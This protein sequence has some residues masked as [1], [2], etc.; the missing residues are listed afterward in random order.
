MQIIKLTRFIFHMFN[1]FV[2]S[3]MSTTLNA[4]TYYIAKTGSDNNNGSL[5]APWQ[6]LD[7]VNSQ[8]FS[9]GDS[10]LFLSGQT[11]TGTLEISS[12]GTANKPITFGTY[13]SGGKPIIDADGL[14]RAIF[15]GVGKHHIIIDGLKV[16]GARGSKG[17]SGGVL[18]EGS[19]IIV[20]N[21]IATKNK[22]SGLRLENTN[23]VSLD[24]VTSYDNIG[25]GISLAKVNDVTVSNCNI[26]RN[27]KIADYHNGIG[28]VGTNIIIQKSK[29]YDN[30][31]NCAE[32]GR[33]SDEPSSPKYKQLCHGIYIVRGSVCTD[34][35]TDFVIIEDNIIYNNNFGNGIAFSASS[36][37]I[38]RNL[39]YDN[40]VA[41]ILVS[42]QEDAGDIYI[43]NNVVH[44]NWAGIQAHDY[45]YNK[46]TRLF[47]Y[48]NTVYNNDKQFPDKPEAKL[49]GEFVVNRPFKVLKI[50]NN[51]F[52]SEN[53]I[54]VRFTGNNNEVESD[55]NCFYRNS[56]DNLIA[57]SGKGSLT[58]GEWRDIS[59]NDIHSLDVNP[60][61][62]DSANNKIKLKAGSA[63]IDAGTDV[64][65][66][67]DI[68]GTSIPQGP[69]PDI[70][71]YEFG[72]GSDKNAPSSPKNVKVT[73]GKA[74]EK[75]L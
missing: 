26:Y 13:G 67:Q 33:P 37:T 42:A 28:G 45:K 27:G 17:D 4:R 59:G 10:I 1:I 52:Y 51:I 70:G 40:S 61:F 29:I 24:N 56:G 71:A 12:S 32:S 39:V 66:T 43:E 31:S 19:D 47:V 20:K 53:R 36:G 74:G 16:V 3:L 55:N 11:W 58:L 18:I 9:P 30:A 25:S 14:K 46:N 49:Y 50:K 65:L 35:E 21:L 6:T 63:C 72:V 22:F 57:Y 73:Q 5:N 54:P 7:K 60:G 44:D 68:V 38:K 41:G 34:C 62:V 48:N 64:G 15:I 69:A 23:R 2:L 75:P 8:S